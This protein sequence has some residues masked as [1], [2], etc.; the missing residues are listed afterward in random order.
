MLAERAPT[1]LRQP[2]PA[3]WIVF[4]G[5]LISLSVNWVLPAFDHHAVEYSPF[6]GHLVLGASSASERDQ[7]L[8]AHSHSAALPSHTHA[9]DHAAPAEQTAS[10]TGAPPAAAPTI[11]G[12]SLLTDLQALADSVVHVIVDVDWLLPQPAMALWLILLPAALLLL[13]RPP[14]PPEQPPRCH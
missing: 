3:W 6:H 5:L 14:P 7:A 11:I 10:S 9:H 8:A 1:A 4:F 2:R 12:T 13:H